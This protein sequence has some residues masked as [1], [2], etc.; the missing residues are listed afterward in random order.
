MDLVAG[1]F[2]ESIWR[3]ARSKRGSRD[4]TGLCPIVRCGLRYH[5]DPETDVYQ[6]HEL[7]EKYSSIKQILSIMISPLFR[8]RHGYMR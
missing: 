7:I 1:S 3:T 5:G 2:G 6:I 4:Q 8:L